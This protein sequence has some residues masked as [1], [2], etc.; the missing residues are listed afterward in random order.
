MVGFLDGFGNKSI[1][2][3]FVYL[4]ISCRIKSF[5]TAILQKQREQ[6][7]YLTHGSRRGYNITQHSSLYVLYAHNELGLMVVVTYSMI[8]NVVYIF[9]RPAY[10]ATAGLHLTITRYVEIVRTRAVFTYS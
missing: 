10:A 4:M 5:R 1:Y 2:L 7:K 9:F 8:A 6:S 3:W